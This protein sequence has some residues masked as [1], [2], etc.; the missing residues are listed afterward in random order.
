MTG[1]TLNVDGR[2][3]PQLRSAISSVT[4]ADANELLAGSMTE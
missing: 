4:I 3:C 2:S 1:Q